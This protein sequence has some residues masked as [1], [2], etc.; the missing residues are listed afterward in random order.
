[1]DSFDKLGLVR[2]TNLVA[3]ALH[4]AADRE[5]LLDIV[6]SDAHRSIAAIWRDL[7][8]SASIETPPEKDPGYIRSV[9]REAERRFAEEGA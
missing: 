2:F 7:D 3:K 6:F 4:K 8:A 1:M 9:L 5:A